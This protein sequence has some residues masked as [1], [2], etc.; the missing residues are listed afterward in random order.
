MEKHSAGVLYVVATPIG[1]LEDLSP[2]ACRILAEVQL[3]AAED[4]RHTGS[5]LAHFGIRTPLLSLHEHNEARRTSRL[6]ER[7]Q[8]GESVALVSDAGTP[9]ISDP[10]FDLVRAACAAGVTVTPIPGP[11]AL[12]AALSVSGLPTDRFV[13]EGFLPAKSAARRARLETLATD[14]RTLVFYEAVHRLKDSLADM[15]QVFGEERAAVVARELTKLHETLSRGT[16]AGLVAAFDKNND[17]LKGEVV[18]LVAG[19]PAAQSGAANIEAERLLRILL[20]ELPVKQAAS[21][22][23]RISG[24]KKNQL[25]AKAIEI[26]GRK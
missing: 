22:A 15:A 18:V 11:S 5:L 2:R 21:L 9:L 13:F 12:I 8:A 24:G 14:T 10:G 17:E 19:A 6:V 7:L 23:A 3:I 16:L 25:Y 26:A 20:E 4:T 1:N